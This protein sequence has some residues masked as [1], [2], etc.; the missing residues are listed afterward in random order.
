MTLAV[1]GQGRLTFN[2][3]KSGR[4]TVTP[5]AAEGYVADGWYTV[6]GRAVGGAETL[7]GATTMIFRFKPVN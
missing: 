6:D 1:E 5:V 2:I 7:T 4:A 3:Q